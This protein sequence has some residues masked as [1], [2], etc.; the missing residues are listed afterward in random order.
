MTGALCGF[1][2]KLPSRGDFVAR[3]LPRTFLLAWRAWTDAA[4]A[5]SRTALGERWLPAWLEGPIWR[6]ALPAATCGPDA[7]LGLMLP[8]VDLAGRHY[9]LTVAAVFAGQ[10]AAPRDDAWLDA[11]EGAA[12]AAL[13]R[14]L[15]PDDLMAALQAIPGPNPGGTAS[16]ASWWTSGSPLVPAASLTLP[17]LPAAGAFAGMI[18]AGAAS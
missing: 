10:S 3:G 17:G 9:P 18:D 12:L 2:G 8:S 11:A 6:F 5:A 4:L 7:V 15:A 1:E 13:D 16:A 14:D